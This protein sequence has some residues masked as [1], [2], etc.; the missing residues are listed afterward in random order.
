MQKN[1][2]YGRC[3]VLF[4]RHYT[5]NYYN[6]NVTKRFPKKREEKENE[7]NHKK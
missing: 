3:K 7:R 6:E 4:A 1:V 2:I 5:D